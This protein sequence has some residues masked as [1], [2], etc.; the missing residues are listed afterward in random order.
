MTI[1]G[2]I[3]L[4]FLLIATLS[5]CSVEAGHRTQVYVTVADSTGWASVHLPGTGVHEPVDFTAWRAERQCEECTPTR[6]VMITEVMLLA[7]G[8]M[9]ARARP[10]E[11]VWFVVSASADPRNR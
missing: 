7:G 3:W 5:A 1:A 10:G 6:W 9:K 2:W 11:T 4:G 8:T